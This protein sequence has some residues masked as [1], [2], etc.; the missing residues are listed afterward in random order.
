MHCALSDVFEAPQ[1]RMPKYI[2][3]NIVQAYPNSR[4]WGYFLACLLTGKCSSRHHRFVGEI[5][6]WSGFRD[7]FLDS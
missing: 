1:K 7:D 3:A 6:L 4:R 5:R 2:H